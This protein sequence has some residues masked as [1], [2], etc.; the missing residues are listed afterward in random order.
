[1]PEICPHCR[2][3]ITSVRKEPKDGR[4]FEVWKCENCEEEWR[5]P[6]ETILNND[7]DFSESQDQI[8]RRNTDADLEW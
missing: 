5:H 4:P 7:L 8:S 1:M 3:P 6:Q 2:E